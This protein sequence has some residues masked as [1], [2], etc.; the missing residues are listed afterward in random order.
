MN[1]KLNKNT[2]DSSYMHLRSNIIEKLIFENLNKKSFNSDLDFPENNYYL[3]DH[4]LKRLNS[5]LSNL[6]FETIKQSYDK[7]NIDRYRKKLSNTA[8][9]IPATIKHKSKSTLSLSSKHHKHHHQQN[10]KNHHHSHHKRASSSDQIDNLKSIEPIENKD[11]LRITHKPKHSFNSAS[12]TSLSSNDLNTQNPIV[13]HVCDESKR[14]KQDFLCPRDLLV[15]EMKYFSY[16]LN[17]NVSNS[18]NVQ[19]GTAHAYSSIPTSALSRKSLDEIDISVHCDINIFDWLMRYVKRNYPQLIEK[20]I[21][22]P[23]SVS[24]DSTNNL[25]KYDENGEIKSIEPK[26]E[27]SNCISILLSSDFLI[28]THL[29][30]KCVLFIVKNLEAVL[31]VPCVMSGIN[32]KL[33]NKMAA[34][35][36]TTKLDELYDK[37]DKLK[38][39]LFQRKIEFLFETCKYK[40]QFENSKILSKW[41]LNKLDENEDL[42]S[43]QDN[44]I[45]YLYECE[46]DASSLFRCKI[47]SRIMTKPQSSKIKCQLAILNPRGEYI[48]LHVPDEKFEI[49]NLLQLLKERLKSWQYVYWFIWALIKSFRC[50]KCS[51]WFRLVELNKCRLNAYTFCPVHDTK[52]NN[53]ESTTSVSNFNS[54]NI[55][56]CIYCEHIVDNSSTLFDKSP[57]VTEA[58]PNESPELRLSKFNK[59]IFEN[60]EK[61]KDVICSHNL[62]SSD[63]PNETSLNSHDKFSLSDLIENTIQSEQ[64]Q[65]INKNNVKN[66]NNNKSLPQQSNYE[67]SF[68]DSITGRHVSLINKN[69]LNLIR[70]YNNLN[71]PNNSES[72]TYFNISNT[73]AN[74]DFKTYLK[75]IS[76]IDPQNIFNSL[77]VLTFLKVDNKMKWDLLKATRL[78]QDNQREDDMKRFREISNYLIKAKLI[79]ENQKP[80]SQ[81]SPIASLISSYNPNQITSYAGGIYCRVENEWKQRIN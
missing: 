26:F 66:N 31:Q 68:I 73:I 74:I 16:N 57:I 23:T 80:T 35:I 72:S 71:T 21:A 13:I 32:E 46:N 43:D 65:L 17:M 42:Q 11:Q 52:I 18:Q 67:S 22:T 49:F 9:G 10:Q 69:V 44:Y 70:G 19:P 36:N 56:I 28:M 4:H 27:I 40:Q 38:T 78:N 51:N 77:D 59:L 81:R 45:N 55:C 12:S 6:P 62:S 1:S 29:V 5:I 61:H 25:I 2:N 34:C 76:K 7:F 58:S 39:K 64:Q 60:I 3:D 63:Y 53:N 54:S 41:K 47:C 8:T 37:K 15:K 14:L 75:L 20:T 24:N 48:F 30:D 79:I 33:L 50:K